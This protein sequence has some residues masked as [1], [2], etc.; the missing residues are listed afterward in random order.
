M[1][2]YQCRY[3]RCEKRHGVIRTRATT[4]RA[5]ERVRSHGKDTKLAKEQARKDQTEQERGIEEREL[6]NGRVKRDY[7]GK[8]RDSKGFQTSKSVWYGDKD[9]GSNGSKGKGKN[10][11]WYCYDWESKDTS[12]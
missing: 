3:A 1:H 9:K 2:L 10:E 6:M 7:G 12:E 8:K 11:T 5:T 4:C